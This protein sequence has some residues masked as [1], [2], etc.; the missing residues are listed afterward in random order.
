MTIR[1]QLERQRMALVAE[2]AE[3]SGRLE[4]IDSGLA[5]LDSA[6][7]SWSD[8]TGMV[9]EAL[10][11]VGIIGCKDDHRLANCEGCGALFTK[12]KR[13]I[14]CNANCAQRTR[15]LRRKT[16]LTGGEA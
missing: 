16:R 14:F 3:V 11:G 12:H 2:R 9:I 8:G 1:D 13:Q 7:A 5:A 10:L 15:N 4:A 6:L